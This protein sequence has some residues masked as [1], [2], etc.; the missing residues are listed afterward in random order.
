MPGRT[1]SCVCGECRVCSARASRR[2]FYQR[3]ADQIRSE[4]A[5]L[6]ERQRQ[7]ERDVS[8]EELDRRA[9]QKWRPEWGRV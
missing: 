8:D 1:P 5:L 7:L 4:A 3:H 2:R 9:L 6:R